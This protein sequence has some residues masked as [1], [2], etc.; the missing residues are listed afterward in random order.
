MTENNGT[1]FADIESDACMMGDWQSR[2]AAKLREA[3]IEAS[4]L[5][6][7]FSKEEVDVDVQ[8]VFVCPGG[9]A[10]SDDDALYGGSQCTGLRLRSKSSKPCR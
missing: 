9:I 6:K 2:C 4:S 1:A 5:Q 3:E 7:S 8:R 10:C